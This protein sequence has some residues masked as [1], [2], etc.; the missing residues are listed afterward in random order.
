ME[1][2]IERNH[3]NIGL[4]CPICR[5][6][7]Q[8]QSTEQLS[9][10][11]TDSYLLNAL[12][13]HNSFANSISQQQKKKQKLMCL[14]EENEATHYCL[15][16]QEYYCEI[17]AKAHQKAKISKNHQLVSIRE[18]KNQSQI[19]VISK[20]NSQLYCQIHQQ[21]E[22]ELFCEDCEEP[23]C[24]LCVSKHPSHKILVIS[25]IFENE[26]QS[27]IDLINKV[28]LLFFFFYFFFPFLISIS[29]CNLKLII[30]YK[31]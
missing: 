19:N 17:C 10:L 4:K 14:D 23:I 20:S 30:S 7:F 25:D 22:V 21:K 27:L 11:S 24:L 28:T 12:N 18:M 15:D 3:S 9:N 13:I 16:C 6:P 1:I 31:R 26:K 2:Y 5:T 29:L 8:S